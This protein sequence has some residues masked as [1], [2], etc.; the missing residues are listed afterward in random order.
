MPAL[1]PILL[2]LGLASPAFA[3]AP[4]TTPPEVAPAVHAVQVRLQEQTFF[5][6]RVASAI[7][8]FDREVTLPQQWPDGNGTVNF[9][10]IDLKA[11]PNSQHGPQA[12]V[13]RFLPLKLGTINFPILNFS[14]PDKQ[15]QT[16]ALKIE[17][18]QPLASQQ[19][20]L[21]IMPQ[22]LSV[23]VGEPL[24]LDLKWQSSIDPA[25]LQ[26][27]QLNPSFFN[28]SDIE[29][30]VPRNTAA[31]KQKIGLPLGGRRV[32]GTR[33]LKADEPKALGQVHL[34]LYLRFAQA[35]SYTIPETRL[36][37]IKLR[38][39]KSEFGRY[40]AY[41]N[42][43]LFEAYDSTGPYQRIFTTAP[44]IQI[45][46]LPLPLNET[47]QPFSGLFAPLDIELTLSTDE[48]EIGQLLQLELKLS[49]PSPHGMLELPELKQQA[50]LRGRFM[51]DAELG[52]K[53]HDQGSLF[54]ARLRALSTSIQALPALH[55][56][57]LDP[58]SGSYQTLST[59][60]IPLKTLPN[61]GQNFIALNTFK[62]ATLPL[63]HQPTGI[64]HNLNVNRMNDILNSLFDALNRN[65]WALLALGPLLFISFF[66]LLRERRRR[67]QD[68]QYRQRA[69]AY[70]RFKKIAATA[71][72]KWPAFIDFMAVHFDSSSA[73][74]TQADSQ[75][76][77]RSIHASAQIIQ[78]V[79][80]WH[81]SADARDFSPPKPSAHFAQLDC[82]AKKILSGISKYALVL[83]CCITIVPHSAQA[84]EWTE[85]Q[86]NF[87]QAHA[88][89]AGGDA[90]L[91]LYRQS[92]LK[93]QAAA[94]NRQHT[95]EAW[96]NAGNAWF[97]ANAIGRAILA[98]RNALNYR[99]FDPQLAKNLAAAR[100]LRLNDIPI[101]T[102]QTIP[103][104]W[105]SA[106]VVLSQLLF[107]SSLL[108]A[109]RYRNRGLIYT[110]C[111]LAIS[112]LL[113]TA[114]L[115]HRTQANTTAGVIIVESLE[116][117]KGP[118]YAYANAFNE[119]LYDGIEFRCIEQRAE[120]CLVELTDGRRCWLLNSQVDILEP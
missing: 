14:S 51:L 54:Q 110:S 104:R 21:T 10:A 87:E 100:A 23:Y 75:K 4:N 61:M 86:S 60:P 63:T 36:E 41:F 109:V 58:A 18:S 64:W 89:A 33:Q 59:P 103:L 12:V 48:I 29:V 52:R 120:W 2:L 71:P 74:W 113:S 1:I 9:L 114:W 16:Q 28:H 62:N 32:I 112:A 50:G 107:W 43:S 17:V 46:V 108:A 102:Q 11:T 45:E 98:Y 3:Q 27:L 35:G 99:P 68:R 20:S 8:Y 65:F 116:A 25:Q 106:W 84:S 115:W 6:D 119:A 49:G 96:L 95:G 66:P 76:A 15:Y 53:W 78:Q 118:A 55:F 44:S 69:A 30:V 34:P 40:A 19:M 97:E 117:R 57:L 93:F 91:A 77:L 90:A 72:E 42:N 26:S 111:L 83:L 88:L 13:M 105:W 82:V 31:E 47:G 101:T 5:M 67:A 38:K 79:T 92:A 94:N 56:L 73:A 81:Q 7:I 37:C 24:Q 39:K 22:K 85:A 80:D 70:K